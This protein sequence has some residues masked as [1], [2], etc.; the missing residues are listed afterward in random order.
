MQRERGSSSCQQQSRAC[1]NVM[2]RRERVCVCDNI[3]M[4]G[5]QRNK[6]KRCLFI[7]YPESP[8]FFF[9]FL[10]HVLYIDRFLHL[11]LPKCT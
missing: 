6:E 9:D 3:D 4:R 8:G 1:E 7:I 5:Q 2:V 11:G 10:L